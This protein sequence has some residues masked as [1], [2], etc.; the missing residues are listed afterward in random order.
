[1]S[2]PYRIG[3]TGGIA[4]GKSQVEFFLRALG[5]PVLD[6]DRVAHEVMRAGTA[7]HAAIV[8]RFGAEVLGADGEIH[9]PALGRIVFADPAAREALNRIV[10]PETG[11]RWRAWL[12]TQTTPLAVVAIPLLFECGVEKQ[13]DG[14][15]CVRAPVETMIKRLK[16]R[17]LDEEQAHLRIQSQWPVARKAALSTWVLENDGSLDDLRA[18]V[19]N[20]HQDLLTLR[21]TP[22]V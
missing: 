22:H 16:L 10:H 18:Q 4:A 17:G 1:M 12:E 14:I 8:S 9:R 6:T 20:W 11:R 21:K 7:E 13:F 15:L 19:A 2:K 5:V 3:L